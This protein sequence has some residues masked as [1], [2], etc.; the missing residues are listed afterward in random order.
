MFI[1]FDVIQTEGNPKN[2]LIKN[3]TVGL[4]CAEL[5]NKFAVR[6]GP[7]T[8]GDVIIFSKYIWHSTERFE[9]TFPF[10][11]RAVYVQRFVE[12]THTQKPEK[13]K[14]ETNKKFLPNSH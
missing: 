7:L 14:R 12:V 3:S 9:E 1:F 4:K 6:P 10:R 2:K 11:G 8:Q 5:I 13:K